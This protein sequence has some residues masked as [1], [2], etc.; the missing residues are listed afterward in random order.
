MLENISSTKRW[1]IQVLVKSRDHFM[2]FKREAFNE[3]GQK[4]EF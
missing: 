3:K 4:N 2:Y 1:I